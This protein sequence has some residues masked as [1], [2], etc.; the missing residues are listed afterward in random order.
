MNTITNF[1][2]SFLKGERTKQNDINMGLKKET[3]VMPILAKH[4]G[5]E[6]IKTT[7][8]YCPYDFEAV[9]SKTRYE[10][11]S[12]RCNYN[13]YPTTII[14]INKIQGTEVICFVFHFTDGLYYVYYN[15]HLFNTFKVKQIRTQRDGVWGQ[16]KAHFEI[17]ID[18]L[19]KINI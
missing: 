7:D 4:F 5:E 18:Q 12:R 14:P 17:P 1:P 3:E 10:L 19:V 6:L 15:E 11:K 9:T 2:S 16:L 8:T 13:T